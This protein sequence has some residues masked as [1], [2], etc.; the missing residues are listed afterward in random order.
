MS[1]QS[2]LIILEKIKK[3]NAP[4][5]TISH[6]GLGEP[7]LDKNLAQKISTEKKYFP[8]ADITV[9]TN[10]TM[11]DEVKAG[12]LFSAGVNQISVSINAATQES[13]VKVVGQF[14]YNMVVENILKTIKIKNLSFPKAKIHVSLVPTEFHRDDETAKFLAFWSGKADQVII[15]PWINWGGHFSTKSC[16]AKWPCRYIW[17]VFMIDWDGKVKM[18]CED[19][20]TKYP[21]GDILQ[22]EPNHIFNSPLIQK[23]RADQAGNHF[24]KPEICSNCI[25]T[26]DT[27]KQYWIYNNPMINDSKTKQ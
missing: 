2:H 16:G 8:D 11:L 12:E 24:D 7:L 10:G 25:E 6:A 15:P 3:W 9:F 19:Y 13:Y 27:A 1:S 14:S 5:S 23:Q 22:E 26:Q 21:I 18:C 17:N 4:I 20:D